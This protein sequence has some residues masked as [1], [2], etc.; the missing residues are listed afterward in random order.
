ML[1]PPNLSFHENAATFL[2][3]TP[4]M[5]RNPVRTTPPSINPNADGSG[6]GTICMATLKFV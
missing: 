1:S 2:R 4:R 3:R 5:T 6:T